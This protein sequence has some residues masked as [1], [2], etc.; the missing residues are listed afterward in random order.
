[1]A[2]LILLLMSFTLNIKHE[3]TN[4]YNKSLKLAKKRRLNND[5]DLFIIN[6]VKQ[7]IIVEYN[8]QTKKE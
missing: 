6:E 4:K 1:M 8:K 7:R 5:L 2:T 3:L